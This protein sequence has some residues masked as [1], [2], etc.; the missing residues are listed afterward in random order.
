MKGS[1]N[2]GWWNCFETF[3][4]NLLFVSNNTKPITDTLSDAG[5]TKREATGWLKTH[6]A[7]STLYEVVMA[8]RNKLDETEKF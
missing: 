8:Y 3:A 7:G 6:P 1:F 2:Q 5:I 4:E